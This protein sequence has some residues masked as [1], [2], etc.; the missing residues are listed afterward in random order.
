MSLIVQYEHLHPILHKSFL[1]IS[2]LVSA[3]GSVNT[4]LK[5]IFSVLIS[6]DSDLIPLK[7][8]TRLGYFSTCK[9]D[10]VWNR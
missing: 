9:S 10:F 1:L 6:L 5:F 4:L 3:S 8:E 2:L 7:S